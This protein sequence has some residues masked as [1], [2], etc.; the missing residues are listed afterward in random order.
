MIRS[1]SVALV[2]AL[3][4]AGTTV[5]VTS[6]AAAAAPAVQYGVGS[7]SLAV[8]SA[9]GRHLYVSPS[10]TDSYKQYSRIPCLR[11][12][13]STPP[14]QDA[15]PEPTADAPLRTVQAAV[16][17]AHAGDVIVVR[18]GTYT[19]AVGWGLTRGT[20]TRPVVLQAA[21]GERVEVRGT[22]IMSSPD[23]WTIQGIRFLHGGAP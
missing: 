2:L 11:D 6:S 17:A 13:A 20:S 21:P 19:E 3:V 15:C 8:P 16:R 10:G 18:S 12:P 9:G 1:L 22:L 4:V 5:S 23:Y 14:Y 7:S